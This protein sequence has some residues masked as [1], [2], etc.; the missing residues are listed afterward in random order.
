MFRNSFWGRGAGGTPAHPTPSGTVFVTVKEIE[1]LDLQSTSQLQGGGATFELQPWSSGTTPSSVLGDCLARLGG[2]RQCWGS[3]LG[4]PL[5]ACAPR[6]PSALSAEERFCVCPGATPGN[7]P[8]SSWRPPT[9]ASGIALRSA[10]PVPGLG[11]E[12]HCPNRAALS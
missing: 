9:A 2:D 8:A 10:E 6:K 4:L 5:K 11:T 3:G 7:A 12:L 1:S